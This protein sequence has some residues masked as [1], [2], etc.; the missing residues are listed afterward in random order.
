MLQIKFKLKIYQFRPTWFG[1]LLTL[2]CIPI[3]I[4]LGIWQYNKAQTKSN[5]QSS[6]QLAEKKTALPFP[7]GYLNTENKANH[8][9]KY[10]KVI[11]SGIYETKYQFCWTTKL[12]TV[13]LVTM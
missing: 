13:V 1:V 5:L 10:K 12:K 3:F 6:Y 2:V 9:W 11:L 8:D 4:N 7:M